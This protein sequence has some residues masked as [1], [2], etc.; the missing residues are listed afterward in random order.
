MTGQPRVTDDALVPTTRLLSL[1]LLHRLR[2]AAAHRN[3]PLW[4]DWQTTSAAQDIHVRGSRV[5]AVASDDW[6][7]CKAAQSR[8]FSVLRSFCRCPAAGGGYRPFCPPS[9]F[10]FCTGS[11]RGRIFISLPS[12]PC[13]DLLTPVL[14]KPFL[15][16]SVAVQSSL[17]RAQ[18][19]F[20][21][22]VHDPPNKGRHHIQWSRGDPSHDNSSQ[23]PRTDSR[24]L[25][26][27]HS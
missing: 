14:Q 25:H 26:R 3:T 4:R 10:A 23:I 12:T 24:P 6:L 27:A 15:S 20:A 5:D 16:N 9:H 1:V 22:H 13:E 18:S 17:C 2:V 19:G 21:L 7:S 11:L 8:R